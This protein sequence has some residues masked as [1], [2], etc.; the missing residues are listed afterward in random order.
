[1]VCTNPYG[2]I[3]DGCRCCT[4][5]VLH[6]HN[7]RIKYRIYR[8]NWQNASL[9]VRRRLPEIHPDLYFPRSAPDC[10]RISLI[11]CLLYIRIGQAKLSTVLGPTGAESNGDQSR[12]DRFWGEELDQQFQCLMVKHG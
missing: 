7:V 2:K 6:R 1:M 8:F 3:G 12:N 11:Q 9:P 10:T 4:H 5:I